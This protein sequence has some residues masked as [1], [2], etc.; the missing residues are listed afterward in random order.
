MKKIC[1]NLAFLSQLESKN[2]KEAEFEDNWILS[3]KM[4]YQSKETKS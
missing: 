1:A 2:F 4:N 3:C